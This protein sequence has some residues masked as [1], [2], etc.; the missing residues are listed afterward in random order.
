MANVFVR[1][2]DGLRKAVRVKA[3]E[4]GI[5]QTEWLTRAIEAALGETPGDV[6]KATPTR[7]EK[8]AKV[9]PPAAVETTGEPVC[10]KCGHREGQHWTRGC[11]VGCVCARFVEQE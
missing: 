9:K 7:V 3:A 4:A 1:I 11:I 8:P 10:R 2:P 5:S 6:P